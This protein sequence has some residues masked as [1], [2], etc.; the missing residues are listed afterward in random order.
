MTLDSHG[1][2]ECRLKKFLIC[3]A[4]AI[5]LVAAPGFAADMPVKARPAAVAAAYN[6][7]GFYV[8]GNIGYG[9]ANDTGNRWDS[10]VDPGFPPAVGFAPYFAA[11][12]NQF[13]GVKPSGVIGGVQAGYNWQ[14]ANWVL[15]VVADIQASDMKASV[16]N[17][18]ELVNFARIIQSNNSRID[19]FG[20]VRGRLGYAANNWLFYGTGGVAYGNVKST[21]GFNCLDCFPTTLWSGTTSSTQVGWAAGAGIEVGLSPN[22]TAGVEYLHFDLGSISTTALPNTAAFAGSSVTAN[23]KFAGDIVRATLNYKFTPAVVAK[24]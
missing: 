22:W 10:F 7:T 18:V 8:G 4:A 2:R 20:T 21:V 24:Y 12:G 13:P 1:P 16:D 11:G 19:W 5:T 3:A 17:R 23:S 6:W 9:W 15:G 14:A